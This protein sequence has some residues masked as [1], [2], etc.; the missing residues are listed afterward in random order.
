MGTGNP[1]FAVYRKIVVF[2]RFACSSIAEFVRFRGEQAEGLF[3]LSHSPLL[4][5]DVLRPHPVDSTS[6]CAY[7]ILHSGECSTR[8]LLET[9]GQCLRV[10]PRVPPHVDLDD[11]AVFL[12]LLCTGLAFALRPH[13]AGHPRRGRGEFYASH[14][15]NTLRS[16]WRN[17]FGTTRRIPLG[18]M[19]SFSVKPV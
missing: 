4:C 18:N 3:L 1:F 16:G 19:Q 15:T 8:S 10:Q 6:R 13:A 17:K 14:P 7:P 12:Q 9:V 5:F 11:S 2:T